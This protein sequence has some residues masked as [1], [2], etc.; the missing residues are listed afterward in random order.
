MNTAG[1]D[2]TEISKTVRK[3]GRLIPGAK[4]VLLSEKQPKWCWNI[5]SI[6][7]LPGTVAPTRNNT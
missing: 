4:S 7:K 3:D 5:R 6:L 2:W 1:N